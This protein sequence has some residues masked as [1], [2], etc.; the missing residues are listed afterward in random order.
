M[1][2][3]NETSIMNIVPY[4]NAVGKEL[5]PQFPL[6]PG[7]NEIDAVKWPDVYVQLKGGITK[8]WFTPY[9]T[10]DKV[11]GEWENKDLIDIRADVARDVVKGCF[12]IDNLNKWKRDSKLSSELRALVDMQLSD[13]ARGSPDNGEIK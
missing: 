4:C 12:N 8:E 13:I 10:P 2:I 5:G 7:W 11:T 6:F 9:G 1:L 3:K